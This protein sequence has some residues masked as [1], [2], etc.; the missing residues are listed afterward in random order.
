VSPPG[1]F[2]NWRRLSV[3]AGGQIENIELHEV[4]RERVVEHSMFAMEPFT[5][6][7]IPVT[8]CVEEPAVVGVG[9]LF[10]QTKVP[11]TRSAGQV[12]TAA[13]Q[14]Q[15]S[16]GREAHPTVGTVH[17]F[18]DHDVRPLNCRKRNAVQIFIP[19]LSARSS[20]VPGPRVFADHCITHCI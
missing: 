15:A 4:V 3:S 16:I 20:N 6:D 2:G 5:I 17:L 19:N 9:P 12:V 11:F 7:D 8:H 1:L 14:L 18:F 10:E 13:L